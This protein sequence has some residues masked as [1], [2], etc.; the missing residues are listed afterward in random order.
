MA[1]RLCRLSGNARAALLVSLKVS[2]ASEVAWTSDFSLGFVLEAMVCNRLLRI[3]D[4]D[5]TRNICRVPEYTGLVHKSFEAKNVP[6]SK[7]R[8]VCSQPQEA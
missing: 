5:F 1:K 6:I 3:P 4:S 7:M 2:Q 8:S